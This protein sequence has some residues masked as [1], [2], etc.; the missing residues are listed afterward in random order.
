MVATCGVGLEPLL[1]A[2]LDALDLGPTESDK[3]AV[4]FAGS[5]ADCWRANW[6]LRTANRVLVELGSWDGSDGDALAQGAQTLIEGDRRAGPDVGALLH[7][8]RTFSIRATTRESRISDLRWAAL[9]VK[10]GLVDGQRRRWRARSSIE[11]DRPDVSL[12]LRLFRDRATLTLDTSGEPLDRR[13]YRVE[14]T[15]APVRENL[16]A[17]CVLAA[18]WSGGG[19]V[20]D[21]MCGSGTLLA[22]AGAVVLGLAPGRL[23]RHWAFARLPSFDRRRWDGIRQEPLPRLADDVTL[24]GVD[25]DRHA[26]SAACTNLEAA[27][28]ADHARIR[29][30]DAFETT[31]PPVAG[32]LLVNPPYGERLSDSREAWKRLGDL[33]KQQYSGYRAVVLA[34]DPGRGKF[35]GLRPSRKI[36]VMN[37]PIAA[38]ILV[39]DLY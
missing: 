33:M 2:E 17:A 18:E 31:P 20:I 30:G 29:R 5:W 10:D 23:R 15:T 12:R 36:P 11:R 26:V 14:T 7:P 8:D 28:L 34:G 6:R 9:R 19:P 22:E 37:G 39:F 21:P 25:Q 16:A 3:G 35:I 13:G 4:R 24:I 27:G 1:A 32:L 38:R